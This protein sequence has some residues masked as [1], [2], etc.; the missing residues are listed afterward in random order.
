[1]LPEDAVELQRR[2]NKALW[3]A[4][5]AALS[6]RPVRAAI[7]LTLIPYH[8]EP[9]NDPRELYHSVSKGGTTKFHAYATAYIA[10]RGQRYTVGLIKVWRG[11]KMDEIV[12][13]LVRLMRRQ[14][15][16]IRLLLLDKGF[17][18]LAVVRYLKRAGC[19]FLMPVVIRG[20]RPAPGRPLR[21]LRAFRKKAN[22]WYKHTLHDAEGRSEEVALCVATKSY[23][24]RKSGKKRI[25]KLLFAAWRF[26]QPPAATRQTY[27]KRFGIESSYRQMNQARIR[28]CTR[29]P[30]MRLLFVG[31]ALVLR[32]VW[33]WLHATK[34]V[35]PRAAPSQQR[36][37]LL[38]FR[39]LLNWLDRFVQTAL[40]SGPPCQ[41]EWTT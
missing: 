37:E 30:L 41:L 19:P 24:H 26:R 10:H 2:L 15:L 38:R 18:S 12:R 33:V 9:L 27:R 23:V 25:K 31:I 13:E 40:H 32:N 21:G 39:R 29:C 3:Y 16:K 4:I 22:G 11:Q 7:D 6:K 20:R 28:T 35:P 34:L 14:G 1:M 17:F 8:G 5:P 36:P